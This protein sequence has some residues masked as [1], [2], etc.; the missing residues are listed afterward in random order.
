MLYKFS[1][2]LDRGLGEASIVQ[3]EKNNVSLV[4][5]FQIYGE[6]DFIKHKPLFSEE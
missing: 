5:V 4:F 6:G 1:W 2:A 3:H